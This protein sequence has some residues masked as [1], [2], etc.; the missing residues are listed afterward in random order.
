MG[1]YNSFACFRNL[2]STPLGSDDIETA[3]GP[4]NDILAAASW[5]DCGPSWDN[6]P[7]QIDLIDLAQRQ[8]ATSHRPQSPIG[9]A[10]LFPV[11]ELRFS[12]YWELNRN[13]YENDH[14]RSPT[15]T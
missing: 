1:G 2:L 9:R 5:R 11:T 7:S 12:A 10:D 3:I 15:P 14:C 6:V 4:A 13:V 8:L